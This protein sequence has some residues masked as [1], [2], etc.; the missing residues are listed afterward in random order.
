MF[1][2]RPAVLS[3]ARRFVDEDTAQDLVAIAFEHLCAH[4]IVVKDAAH[5]RARLRRV[6]RG[7]AVDHLLW[8]YSEGLGCAEIAV[9][10]GVSLRTAKRKLAVARQRLKAAMKI[11]EKSWHDLASS[12]D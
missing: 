8:R 6:V 3:Y 1:R 2:H 9:L 5:L 10:L 4:P 7:H 12:N 11:V